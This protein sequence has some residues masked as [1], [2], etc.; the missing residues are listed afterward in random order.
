M[1]T[2]PALEKRIGNRRCKEEEEEEGEG[3]VAIILGRQQACFHPHLPLPPPSSPLLPLS[4]CFI[5]PLSPR[6]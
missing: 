2:F 3:E 5:P 4:P 6:A 1:C